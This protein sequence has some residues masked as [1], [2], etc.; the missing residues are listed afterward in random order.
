MRNIMKKRFLVWIMLLSLIT[1]PML[2]SPPCMA[3]EINASNTSSMSYLQAITQM[4]KNEYNYELSDQHLLEGTVKGIFSS[5][6]DYTE[7]FTSTEA[8]KF[9]ESVDGNYV[10]IG[11]VLVEMDNYI[12]VT[13]V[14]PSSPAE[15]A[16][17]L[18]GDKIATVN[19]RDV[20]GVSV[21][22]VISLI[23]GQ[24]NSQVTLGVI[25]N[26]KT[27]RSITVTRKA[28]KLNPVNYEIRND[29]AY[30]SIDAFNSNTYEYLAAALK[31]ID[32]A[33]VNR[34]ILDLRDNTGGEV[35]QAVAVAERFVPEGVITSLHF[36][37]HPDQDTVYRSSLQTSPYKLAVLVNDM[38]A[39]ASEILAGAIQDSKAGKLVG[40]KTYGKARVQTIIPILT[41]EAYEK[42][43]KKA[44]LV[45]ADV[46]GELQNKNFTEADLLGWAKI[47]TAT[48]TT[49][50]GKMIDGQ[51][52]MP[53]YTVARHEP[54]K[55][56]NINSISKLQKTVK[57]GLNDQGI[58]VYNAEKVLRISNYDV[59]M[60]DMTLDAKTFAAIKQFQQDHG[61]GSYG[62]LD[63]STQEALNQQFYKLL[64]EIDRQYAR[65]LEIV[66]QQ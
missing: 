17:I 2:F 1:T 37:K 36:R 64:P 35:D 14:F 12:V 15:T 32:A 16:G 65:A 63:F 43:G 19:G 7:F 61:L 45:D 53:D 9:I 38:T 20:I 47:T 6:D 41:P 40:I 26:N 5:M 44:G 13:R 10:G 60:P 58:D 59:D 50:A 23:R 27:L 56:V 11:V 34:I 62:I 54:V 55:D 30:V 21:D 8:K 4:A 29:I 66:R 39:S 51:G 33:G 24:S 28:I 22:E 25:R 46:V 18:S 42:Y 48:Y 49:P 52:L 31:A 57:P 3:A